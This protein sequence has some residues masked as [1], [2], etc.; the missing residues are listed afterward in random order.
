MEQEAVICHRSIRTPSRWSLQRSSFVFL[1][2]SPSLFSFSFASH[3]LISFADVTRRY[4]TKW[5]EVKQRRNEVGEEWLKTFLDV[6]VYFPLD[7]LSSFPSIFLPQ[8]FTNILCSC[9]EESVRLLMLER[10]KEE[11][12]ELEQS[13]MYDSFDFKLCEILASCRHVD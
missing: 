6:S 10:S 8:G 1:S 13:Q 4:T 12:E 11:E 9:E 3:P 7:I 5:S 2:F